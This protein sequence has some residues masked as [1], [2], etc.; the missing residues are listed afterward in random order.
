MSTYGIL[1][2]SKTANIIAPLFIA[3]ATDALAESPPNFRRAAEGVGAYCGCILVNKVLKEMQSL[4]YLRVQQTAFIEISETT[5]THLHKLSLEWHLKKKMG[6]VLRSMDRGVTASNQMVQYVFLYL[7][8]TLVECLV[9]CMIFLLHFNEWLIAVII[10]IALALYSW[11]TGK[12]STVNTHAV[13][14]VLWIHMQ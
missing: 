9:V 13:R 6:D 8:P 1:V 12:A 5:F 7:F 3:H 2:G 4:V 11:V 10:I 14:V